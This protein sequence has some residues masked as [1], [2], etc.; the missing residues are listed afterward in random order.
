M[1]PPR[2]PHGT[3]DTKG[4]MRARPS[5]GPWRVSDPT[6]FQMTLVA[7]LLATVL[8]NCGPPPYLPFASPIKKLYDTDFKTGTTLRYTCHLGYSKISSSSV[9]CNDRGSW[10]YSAFC[11]KKQCRNL[12]DLP[13]GKVEVKTDFLFGSTVEFS[14]SEGYIL[15][16]STT[17]HCDIQGRGVDWSDPLPQCIIAKC[18]PPPAISNGKHNGEDEDLYTYGSSVTYSCDPGFSMLG[19]ASISCTVEN[20]AIGVWNP[21][22]P[23]CKNIVCH[24][25]QVPNGII[26]SGFGPTYNYKNSLVFSCKKGYVLKGSHLIRCEANNKWHPSPPIC[27]LN[28]CIGLPDIPHAVWNR[29]GYELSNQEVFAVGTA[30]K[31]QCKHGYRPIPDEPLTVT[32]QEN[33]TWTPSEGCEQVCCPIP[34]PKNGRITTEKK[35]FATSCVHFYGDVVSYT[36][37]E[38]YKFEAKCQADGMWCPEAPTCDLNCDS[39][40]V[41]AHGHHKLISSFLG[42]KSGDAIYKCDEGYTLVGKNKL[43]CT[44]SGWSPA[45]PQCKALCLKPEIE[46]GRLSVDKDGYVE[47]EN[48]TVQCDSGYALVGSQSITCLEDR[49]WYPEVPKCEWEYPEGCE[50]VVKGKKL[51]QC[52][53]TPE[54]MRLALEVYKLYLEIQQLELQ[55]HKAK[56]ATQECSL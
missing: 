40:P 43:S 45:A 51:M 33:F 50:Q 25:P 21:S 16:G 15:V 48:V 4:K 3:L 31:Y 35:C 30:L 46:H 11:A 22:P 13:N 19:K 34:E 10:D 29:R 38:Q 27:E 7:A 12:E 28:S 36:S 23:T 2:V 47:P 54:E 32:C 41:I 44:S 20:K 42:L 18:E 26:V 39:P 24:R 1:C 8:G 14:C 6:L 37:Y 52:L 49:T 17:S 53:P 5:S 9:T 55:N 56:Q